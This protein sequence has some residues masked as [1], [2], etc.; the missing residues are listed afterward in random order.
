MK[1][2]HKLFVEFLPYLKEIMQKDIMASVTDLDKFIAY[3]P[4]K[5]IDVKAIKGMPIP[6]G[7]PLRA[8]ISN[9]QIISAVVPKEVYGVPFRAVTYPIRDKN[10]KC[11]GAVGVAETLEKEQR[12]KDALDEIMGKITVSNE[13]ISLISDDINH[14][15]LDMQELSS[16]VEEVNASVLEITELSSNINA[17]VDLVASSSQNVIVEAKEGI[18][19]VK[20]INTSLAATVEDI[21][22]VK[23]QIEHLFIS[24][25]NANK[26]VSLINNIAEQTNLLAL[27]ASIEAARAGEHGR[28][29]AVVADEVGKL[30][31]QSKVSSIEIADMM[32]NIQNE[33]K[34]VV[35]RV[36]ETVKKTDKNKEGIENATTNIER[37]LSDIQGVNSEIQG[38]KSEINKQA[39]NTNEIR[40]AV[41]SIT[42]SVEDK[43]SFGNVINMKL[44]QQ[45]NDL[46]R[47]ESEIKVSAESLL[48]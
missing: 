46:D 47:F 9:N 31:V 10:G 44:K 36:N 38:V 20:N 17:R 6:D 7:D 30:A 15:S 25:E 5:A 4:G 24:I 14:M 12:I 43:A 33:I 23:E 42:A 40:L 16:V 13:G 19:S 1:K 11:I 27:N 2:E 45:S 41:D 32:K 18:S 35:E 28:G 21:L 26:T 37:I 29:F 22:M 8:T 3:V 39:S 34:G 48:K